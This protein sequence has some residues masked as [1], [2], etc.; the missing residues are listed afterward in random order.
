MAMVSGVQRA[1]HMH[2]CLCMHMAALPAVTE[3]GPAAPVQSWLVLPLKNRAPILSGFWLLE[4]PG[5]ISTC[6]RLRPT[7]P[8]RGGEF[9]LS[10]TMVI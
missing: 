2:P 8:L 9:I 4:Q 3:T 5:D 1:A 10:R 6:C 7:H